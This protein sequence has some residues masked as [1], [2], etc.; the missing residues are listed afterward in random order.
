M[1][2]RILGLSLAALLASGT[3]ALAYSEEGTW[4]VEAMGGYAFERDS[5]LEGGGLGADLDLEAG[6]VGALAAGYTFLPNWRIE[7]QGGYENSDVEDASNPFIATGDLTVWSF[8]GNLYRD[9]DLGMNVYPFVGGGVGI[10]LVEP[11]YTLSAPPGPALGVDDTTTTFA[12]QAMGG[13]AFD[14]AENLMGTVRYRYFQANDYDFG[15]AEGDF[16]SHSVLAGLR[17]TW[18]GYDEP[19]ADPREIPR[20]VDPMPEP[21]LP[22]EM[23][24]IIYFDFDD[25]KIRADQQAKIDRVARAV[26]ERDVTVIVIVGHADTSGR[27]SYNMKLS[28]RRAESVRKALQARGVDGDLIDT[29]FRGESDPAVET[30]DGVREQENRRSTVEIRFE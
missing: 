29:A 6:F 30:G 17:F 11:E 19:E 5:E 9:F 18:G 7:L 25:D 2:K 1:Q 15:A 27:A 14:L 21:D 3:S 23:R 24:E 26:D 4:Y 8:M 28:E 13:L 16:T 22:R 10:A 12:W 20:P